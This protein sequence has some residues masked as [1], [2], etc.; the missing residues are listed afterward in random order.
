MK[1]RLLQPWSNFRPGTVI[2]CY[3]AIGWDLVKRG[4]AQPME[5]EAAPEDARDR[6][7]QTGEQRCA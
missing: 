5:P 6:R 1:I 4:L 2:D 3:P 7:A